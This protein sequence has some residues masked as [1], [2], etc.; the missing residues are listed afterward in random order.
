MKLNKNFGLPSDYLPLRMLIEPLI[1]L[2][3]PILDSISQSK[4]KYLKFD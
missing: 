4:I 1:K 2:I 3:Q